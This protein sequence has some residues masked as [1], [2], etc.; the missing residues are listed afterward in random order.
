MRCV[1]VLISGGPLPSNSVGRLLLKRRVHFK[2]PGCSTMSMSVD[3]KR[4]LTPWTAASASTRDPQCPSG[5]ST[6]PPFSD[7][8]SS[9]WTVGLWRT[10]PA[11]GFTWTIRP[12]AKLPNIWWQPGNDG[13]RVTIGKRSV[14]R[15]NRVGRC[16]EAGK[17][18]GMQ[19]TKDAGSRLA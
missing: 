13:G 5:Y 10:L 15:T 1:A 19:W 14:P 17:N 16:W 2:L 18:S 3:S 12:M 8:P 7:R 11:S 9:R 4:S 6:L